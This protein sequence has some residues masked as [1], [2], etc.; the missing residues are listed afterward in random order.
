[1]IL[2]FGA[3]LAVVLLAFGV[4]KVTTLVINRYFSVVRNESCSLSSGAVKVRP[5]VKHLSPEHFRS[6]L[7]VYQRIMTLKRDR[8]VA[9]A[10]KDDVNLYYGMYY[11][12]SNN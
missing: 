2:G 11:R 1:M 12:L 4:V 3:L 5:L 10:P 6:T 9:P 7:Q 8:D